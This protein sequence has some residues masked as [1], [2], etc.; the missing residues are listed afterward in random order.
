MLNLRATNLLA[1]IRIYLNVVKSSL[2]I[3]HSKQIVNDAMQI[4]NHP[5]PHPHARFRF[6]AHFSFFDI[7]FTDAL[8]INNN[9]VTY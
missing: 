7:R 3:E 8:G 9:V 4:I 1:G 5:S 6:H 2:V